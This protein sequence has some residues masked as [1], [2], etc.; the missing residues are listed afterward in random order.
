MA[1]LTAIEKQMLNEVCKRKRSDLDRIHSWLNRM[2]AVI[3]EAPTTSTEVYSDLLGVYDDK[4]KV[5]LLQLERNAEELAPKETATCYKCG[6]EK[7]IDE[8]NGVGYRPYCKRV[9]H[10]STE[11]FDRVCKFIQLKLD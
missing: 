2:H 1:H 5:L 10:C 3:D 9:A 4:I 11:E 8:L 6:K 7:S